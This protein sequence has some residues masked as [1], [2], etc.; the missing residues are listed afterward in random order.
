[1]AAARA[2]AQSDGD[3]ASLDRLHD[4]VS[5]PAVS[6]WPL[7]PG[8][9][10]LAVVLLVLG[11]WLLGRARRRRQHNRYRREALAELAALRGES[12]DP[13]EAAARLRVLLKRTALT[14]YP[15]EEV[16]ALSGPDWW[17]DLDARG[18]GIAFSKGFGATLDAL[19][20]RNET[21]AETASVELEPLYQVAETWIRRH[22]PAAA[23]GRN[24]AR[25]E[26]RSPKSAAQG[27]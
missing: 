8:W 26:A 12:L 19:A 3:P 20:Y 5:P 25:A 6:W 14:A 10:G 16:A 15:R 2:R 4:V 9:I 24:G 23:I 7:A 18:A 22:R 21:A 17:R 13:G 11:A 27:A 1:L